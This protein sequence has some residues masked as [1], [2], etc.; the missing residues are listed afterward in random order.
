MEK[1]KPGN[2]DGES[3]VEGE[4]NFTDKDA[5]MWSV[6]P[7]KEFLNRVEGQ[8]WLPAR[9]EEGRFQPTA[10][11]EKRIGEKTDEGS[12]AGGNNFEVLTGTSENPRRVEGDDGR[13]G[14]HD[15]DR[16]GDD[17]D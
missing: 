12:K 5:T 8:Q 1:W 17:L 6:V 7:W 13:Q 2:E 9:L 11:K 16:E 15:M 10:E 14:K 3:L 4:G